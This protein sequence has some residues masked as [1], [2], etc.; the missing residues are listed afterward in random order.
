M[1]T[2]KKRPV[3]RPATRIMPDRIPA[4]PEELVRAISQGPPKRDGEWDFQKPDGDGYV[5][6]GD[7]RR[8]DW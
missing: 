1:E 7:P 2:K 4:T 6:S 8:P 3:G 5:Q